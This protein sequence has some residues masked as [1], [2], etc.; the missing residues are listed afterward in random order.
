MENSDATDVKQKWTEISYI[1]FWTLLSLSVRETNLSL[2]ICET[3]TN[4][5]TTTFILLYQISIW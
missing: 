2:H 5:T 3:Q 1:A 4:Q